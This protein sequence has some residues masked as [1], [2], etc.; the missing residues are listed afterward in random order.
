M[1]KPD[2]GPA[3]RVRPSF[4]RVFHLKHSFWARKVPP[5]SKG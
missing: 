2:S 3:F 5:V 4:L 1:G